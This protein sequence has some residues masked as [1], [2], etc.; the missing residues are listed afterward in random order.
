[1]TTTKNSRWLHGI[2]FVLLTL[3]AIS[4][5]TVG[6]SGH[7]HG[8]G[9]HG[10]NHAHADE[11]PTIDTTIW[12]KQTELFVEFPAL[13][14]GQVSRFAA[15]FTVLNQHRPVTAGKVTVSLIKGAG[16]IRQTAKAPSSPGIFTPALQP[17]EAG[18]YQLVFDLSTPKYTDKIVV[19]NVKVYPTAQAAKAALQGKP[20][21]GNDISFL[22]EQAWK[23]EFQTSQ[24]EMGEIYE[25]I[26]TS[27][28]WRAAPSSYQ[29]LVATTSGRVR[30]SQSNLLEGNK[31][32]Q[33]QILMT[34]SSAGL[35]NNNQAAEIQKAKIDF[36]QAQ[37]AYRRNQGLYKAKVISKADLELIEKQYLLAKTNY[38]TL[39]AGYSAYGK[40]IVVPYNGYIKSVAADNGDFVAQGDA[41]VTIASHQS[42]LLEV[43]VNPMYIKHLQQINNVWFRSGVAVWAHMQQSGGRVISVSREVNPARPMLSVFVQI[44]EAID[45]PEG[46]FSEVQLAV[47]KPI[48]AP[49]V[50]ESALLED[51]GNY[52]VIVQ[53]SGESF[54]RRS[55]TLGQRNGSQVAIIKGLSLGEVVVTKGAYQVKMASMSGQAPAHGHVH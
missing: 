48:K 7:S 42:H 11:F 33:G 2:L 29:T 44:N 26:P 53:T 52:S 37:A 3:T 41:L 31:V 9:A 6:E 51:Y 38:Q 25:T 1:M 40:S 39:S 43:Q 12:T 32:A 28:I 54:E 49:V 18:E 34:L 55:V 50:P 15:H 19:Q 14:V 30:Y 4:C 13:V 47:G 27:G 23:T 46:S 24:V 10:G 36:E 5:Q 35:S 45:M 22:K 20:E 8:N 21:S 16:G 17:K